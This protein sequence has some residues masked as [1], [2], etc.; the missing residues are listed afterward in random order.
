VDEKG[1]FIEELDFDPRGR[2]ETMDRDFCAD[3]VEF[4]G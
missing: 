4:I 2:F 1:D 3:V